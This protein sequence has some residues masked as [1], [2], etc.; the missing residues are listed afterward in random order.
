MAEEEI[1]DSIDKGALNEL[2]EVEQEGAGEGFVAKLIDLFLSEMDKREQAL[3]RAV[4]EADWENASRMAHAIKG[5]CSHFGARQ[6]ADLCVAMET[7]AGSTARDKAVA[8]LPRIL[9]ES[10]RVRA[11]LRMHQSRLG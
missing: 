2:A 11:A 5:S 1:F 3:Q 10:G 6:L 7:A 4:D 8:L 9:T